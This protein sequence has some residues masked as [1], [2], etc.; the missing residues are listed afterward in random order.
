[1]HPITRRPRWNEARAWYVPFAQILLVDSIGLLDSQFIYIAWA[2]DPAGV[3]SC[4]YVGKRFGTMRE[5]LIWHLRDGSDL[6]VRI[7]VAGALNP[8]MFEVMEIDGSLDEAEGWYMRQHNPEIGYRREVSHGLPN[9]PADHRP[10]RSL[11]GH[12]VNGLFRHL[13]FPS[14]DLRAQLRRRHRI[15]TGSDLRM[16]EYNGDVFDIG[17]RTQPNWLDEAA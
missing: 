11:P 9:P 8:I 13:G 1:M 12:R 10:R 16:I 6:G 15:M 14:D 3:K 2:V 7:C 17:D 4:L 5:R